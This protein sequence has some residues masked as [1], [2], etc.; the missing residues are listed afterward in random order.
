MEHIDILLVEDNEGDIELTMEALKEAR[1]LN[2]VTVARDGEAAMTL[3]RSTSKLP[4]LILL[5]INLP[6]MDGMEVLSAIK[7]D[8]EL[9]MIPVIILTTSSS[10]RD[11]SR[12]YANHANCFI[13]KPVDLDLFMGVI[14]N[15]ESFWISIVRLPHK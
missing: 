4:D 12:S 2:R 3:L 11:I 6:K 10:D 15:I 8:N 5:D 14:R 13:T 7:T 9:K 1:I